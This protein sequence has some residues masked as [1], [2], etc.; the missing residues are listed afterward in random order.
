[1]ESQTYAWDTLG[2]LTGR[3]DT[4]QGISETFAYDNLNRVVLASVTGGGS[5]V[6]A[7][8]AIG[9]IASKSDVGSYTYN[10]SGPSSVRPHAVASISGTANQVVNPAYT[11]DANG[12]MTAGGGRT[13]A[14][15]AFNKPSTIVEGLNTL[16]F[17][18]DTEHARYKQVAPE[19]T[20]LYL[21]ASGIAV[22]KVTSSLGV[23]QWNNYLFAGGEM[24]GAYYERPDI[25]TYTRYFHKDHLGS[26][27]AITDENGT[28]V[29][30]NAYDAWGKRRNLNGTD[31][32]GNTLTS[33]T[34]R[35]FTGQEQLQ[36]VGL[37]HFNGRIYDPQLGKFTSADPSVESPYGTQGWN[38]Y[39][40]VGNNPLSFTDPTGF[41]FLGCFWK[42]VIRAISN[43]V[44]IVV[45]AVAIVAQQYELLPAVAG[46]SSGT[47]TAIAASSATAALATGIQ[48]GKLGAA[49]QAG[50]I[51]AASAFAFAEVGAATDGDF[52]AKGFNAAG[53][54]ADDY[55][56][57]LQLFENIAG[58]AAVGCASGALSGGDCGSSAFAG[59]AGAFAGPKLISLG[60]AV[61]E[62][63][64]LPSSGGDCFG[65]RWRQV[66][67]RCDN[68]CIR[69]SL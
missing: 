39:A 15:T 66:R 26:I 55:F 63:L 7:Y 30:C 51:T 40:Y 4:V 47:V 37:I 19:G 17:S 20:T 60:A 57:T 31:D 9:N 13:I 24:I 65:D 64:P 21:N 34:S 54:S 56:G 68:R 6:F 46:L 12:N 44:T 5:K 42:P 41:C 22:E 10:A 62:P 38:R 16:S 49:F 53:K 45:I 59:A 29:E 52:N 3:T 61:E 69:L 28:P 8:D 33:Q 48:S 58:H 32:P 67:E 35:G 11:Y 43:P 50:L 1:V 18:H 14:Y 2:N 36:D 27:V 23:V 25:T